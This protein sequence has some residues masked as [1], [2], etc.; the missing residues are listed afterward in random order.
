MSKNPNIWEIMIF[1]P[2]PPSSSAPVRPGV[3]CAKSNRRIFALSLFDVVHC[4]VSFVW[5]CSP[6]LK[7]RHTGIPK[8]RVSC[9]G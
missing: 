8:L 7:K 3:E 9:Q 2:P 1:Y 6:Q 4:L 5:D